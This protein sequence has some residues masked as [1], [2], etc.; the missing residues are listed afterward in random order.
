MRLYR[1]LL[2]VNNGDI[3]I[4]P[5]HR[6]AHVDLMRCF[7]N[8]QTV[9]IKYTPILPG[10]S[11]LAWLKAASTERNVGVEPSPEG[12][13]TSLGSLASLRLEIPQGEG[14]EEDHELAVI[15]QARYLL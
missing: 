10:D 2:I 3:H 13:C 1:S 12:E 9:D 7:G 14:I 8:L 6:L 11:R 4:G 5:Q 15:Q